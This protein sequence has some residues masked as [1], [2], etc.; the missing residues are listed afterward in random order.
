[1]RPRENGYAVIANVRGVLKKWVAA[2]Q[3]IRSAVVRFAIRSK[4]LAHHGDLGVS[5]HLRQTREASKQNLGFLGSMNPILP[6]LR[7]INQA[8]DETRTEHGWNQCFPLV[9]QTPFGNGLSENSVS[10]LQDTVLTT[11]SQRT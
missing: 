3:L 6:R 9:P 7:R 8:T 1:M 4:H 11:E 10:N 2:R 5:N